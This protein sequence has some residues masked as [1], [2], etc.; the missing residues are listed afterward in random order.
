MSAEANTGFGRLIVAI[1]CPP[2]Y[3]FLRGKVAAGLIHSVIYLFALVTV[4]FGIGVFFWL[5]GF[6]HAYWDF[7]HLKQEQ[8]IQRQATVIAEKMTERRQ[9]PNA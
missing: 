7:A 6:V 8:V 1:F 2:L 3:F 4:I 9:A 5:V